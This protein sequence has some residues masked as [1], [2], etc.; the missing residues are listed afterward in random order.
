[1]KK[2]V[3]Q[4]YFGRVKKE[5]YVSRKAIE[6]TVNEILNIAS[7]EIKIPQK[8]LVVLDIGSGYGFYSLELA[9][10][11]KCVI[12]VEPF[13]DAFEIAEKRKKEA[14]VG[15]KVTFFNE[16]IEEFNTKER[17]HF[18][19]SLTTFEHM[20][21]AEASFK[22]TFSLLRRGGVLYLT[23]P[24]KLWP[25]EPHYNLLFLSWLPLSPANFYMKLA[26][27]GKSYKD[28][29]YS[30]S[31]FG[32]KKFFSSFKYPYRFILPDADS[33][34]LGCNTGEGVY[35]LMRTYG[36]W[37]IKKFPI[38]WTMSKGFIIVVK[39]K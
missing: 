18:A 9:R 32:M 10:H 14:K 37:L 12:G 35:K 7:D 25:L 17:F 6:S 2:F 36:I 26:R 20:P 21:N 34:Y 3:K 28:C 29:S 31:Y 30:R 8:D 4:E 15:M 22:K 33:V 24:N 39:K 13:K 1:M 16:L 27:K 19:I 23:A 38:F 11:V 5:E